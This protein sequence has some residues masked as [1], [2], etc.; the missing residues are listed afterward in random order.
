MTAPRIVTRSHGPTNVKTTL[1]I[2]HLGVS[3]SEY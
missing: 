3:I 2:L 1:S